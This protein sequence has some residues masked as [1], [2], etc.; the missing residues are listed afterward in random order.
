ML[1][2]QSDADYMGWM[3]SAVASKGKVAKGIAAKDRATV[4]TEAKSME[5]SFKHIED[6]WTKKGAADAT[7][8]AKQAVSRVRGHRQSR[9][10]QATSMPPTPR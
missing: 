2:A 6:Y 7:G 8:F 3:K 5:D 1:L 4:A 9:L 10:R